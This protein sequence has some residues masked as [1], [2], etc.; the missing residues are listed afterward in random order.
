[1][2]TIIPLVTIILLALPPASYASPDWDLTALC[3]KQ[4]ERI[5]GLMAALDLTRPELA[6]V[7]A[8]AQKKDWLAACQA[9][10]AH[11]Q[12]R[13]APVEVRNNKDANVQGA[14]AIMQGEFTFFEM[15]APIQ[16]TAT[17]GVDWEYKG[18]DNDREWAWIFNRQFYLGSLV[19]AYEDTGRDE[20]VQTV[21]SLLC[22]WVLNCPYNK[23]KCSTAQW[24]GLEAA[25]RMKPWEQVFTRLQHVSTFR[26]VTRIL[27]L[28]SLPDH[29]YY[30]KNFHSTTGNWVTME[31]NGLATIALVWP[32]FKQSPTWLQYTVDTMVPQLKR[33]VY[34][35]GAQM[36][37]TSHYHRVAANS[38]QNF[39]DS[40]GASVGAAQKELKET[41]E[42]MWNY[43]AMSIRPNGHGL[44]NNDSDYDHNTPTLLSKADSYNRE[45]W[46]YIA[47]HGEQGATPQQGPSVFFPWAGH[48]ILRSGWE[49]D[50][51]W[52]FFDVG[53]YGTGHQHRDKLHFSLSPYGRDI[54]TDS[55]RFTY[56]LGP[57]RDHFHAAQSHNV[58]L[59]D[60]FGCSPYRKVARK[61]LEGI[62][63]FTPQW[64]YVRGVHNGPFGGLEGK[65]K[66]TR[67]LVYIR[68][69]FWIVL[70]QINTNRPRALTTL[71]QFHPSC[72]V[73][74][75][76]GA[77]VTQDANQPNLRLLPMEPTRWN[78]TLVKGQEEPTIQGWYSAK[79]T[80]KTP[81][82]TA[83]CTQDIKGDTLMGW[84]FL[85]GRT[86]APSGSATLRQEKD[87]AIVEITQDGKPAQ[88]YRIA[89]T[90]TPNVTLPTP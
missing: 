86:S 5:E 18:P 9:L 33:Q 42:H 71:W 15:T 68:N 1:M 75:E 28:S 65:V 35:D 6:Q 22:D 54:L 10:L 29:A 77:L 79:Y 61:P 89:L 20:F 66:H 72:S 37:L 73:V 34:P 76:N 81:A 31:M 63:A 60:G 80:R 85:P 78:Y 83:L 17:G 48:A 59:L 62:H 24:R 56:V 7:Q 49:K 58:I 3:Q 25:L 30:L 4:P 13:F 50:A 14:E 53:P 41:L 57:W 55:G 51:H 16:R 11:Y 40:L 88:E 87:T 45:D 39:S 23:Q 27:M 43:L 64:D 19:Q 21:D 90:G 84:V 67:I 32:E 82:F 26:P 36:E 2:R 47:T 8:A 46:R 69:D 74:E 38:F 44:L 12:D 70:D 52:A